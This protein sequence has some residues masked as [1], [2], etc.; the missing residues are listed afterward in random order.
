MK[1]EIR[2]EATKLLCDDLVTIRDKMTLLMSNETIDR[3]R[4]VEINSMIASAAEYAARIVSDDPMSS[5]VVRVIGEVHA[6][7]L[8]SWQH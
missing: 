8:L 5:T 4:L 2:V 7:N 6:S 3:H 1:N